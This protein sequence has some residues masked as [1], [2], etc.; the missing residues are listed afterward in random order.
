MHYD[1]ETVVDR[2]GLGSAKW[3]SM[4]RA[5]PDV[6]E[7]IIPFSTADMELKTAPQILDGLRALF[8]GSKISLGYTVY[9]QSYLDAVSGWMAR[10]HN[11][12]VDMDW[13]VTSP[14]IVTALYCAVR[15]YTEPGDGVIIFSPVYYPFGMAIEHNKRVIVDVPLVLDGGGDAAPADSGVS[16]NGDRTQVG[17]APADGTLADSYSDSDSGRYRIDWEGFE[18]AAKDEKNKL[19]IFCSPHNPVSRVWTREELERVSR[20]CIDNGVFVVSDEIHNDLVM[21]GYEHTVFATLSEDA[22]RNSIICTSPSKTF[23]L[24]GL[25]VSNNFVPDED[26]RKRLRAEIALSAGF[27]LNAVGYRACEIAYNEGADWLGQVILLIERNARTAE[28]FFRERIPQVRVFPLEGTY[29]Q[30][31]DCRRLFGDHKEMEAFMQTKALLFLDEG[32]MFGDAGIG[33]ERMNLA[34][35]EWAIKEALERLLAA[36]RSNGHS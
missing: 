20:I 4:K 33:F 3:G 18:A 31:W 28:A 25:Q 32:Y 21:P 17:T 12:D 23:S 7:G 6:P 15:A 26:R 22:A 16:P 19:L 35:P 8:D 24:A 29:L 36:L 27:S 10:R 14:G 30:W 2:S 5:N 1:F 34:C 13:L 9:T 11:W